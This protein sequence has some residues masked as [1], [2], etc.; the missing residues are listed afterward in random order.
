MEKYLNAS[1]DW[2]EHREEAARKDGNKKLVDQIK[3]E[4][5]L[6]HD[7]GDLPKSAQPPLSLK[8]KSLRT[9]LENSFTSVVKEYKKLKK[10]ELATAAEKELKEVANWKLTVEAVAAITR[11]NNE[12]KIQKQLREEMKPAVKLPEGYKLVWNDEFDGTKVD[13][14]KWNSDRDNWNGLPLS[15]D[16]VYLDG[17]G[18][19]NIELKRVNQTLFGGCLTSKVK[20]KY[21]YFEA[22]MRSQQLDGH[23]V[24]LSLLSE[25]TD[26][27]DIFHYTKGAEQPLGGI[28]LNSSQPNMGKIDYLPKLA[29]YAKQNTKLKA[30]QGLG[31]D[32][33]IHSLLWT[34]KEFIF[35][36]NGIEIYRTEAV[37]II[38][39]LKVEILFDGVRY[40]PSGNSERKPPYLTSVDYVRVFQKP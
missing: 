12:E 13:A 36:L 8:A 25:V 38:K 4:W 37:K 24:G 6:F 23:F 21:G 20:W 7:K 34:E 33:H 39:E 18:H 40:D 19:A 14:S 11:E 27:I 30:T 15:K 2:F 17:K 3:A 5:L 1:R 29:S 31:E 22:R 32:Y 16:S 10:D 35:Y 9:A 28:V 26:C